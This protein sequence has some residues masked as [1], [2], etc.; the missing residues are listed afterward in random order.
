[1]KLVGKDEVNE[2]SRMWEISLM[3]AEDEYYNSNYM[4]FQIESNVLGM[5]NYNLFSITLLAQQNYFKFLAFHSIIYKIQ[6]RFNKDDKNIDVK[7]K[8]MHDIRDEIKNTDDYHSNPEDEEL[9]EARFRMNIIDAD[10]DLL[11]QQDVITRGILLSAYSQLENIMF[12]LSNIYQDALSLEKNI[13]DIKGSGIER[14]ANYLKQVKGLEQLKGSQIWFE[15][16]NW[17]VIRNQIAHADG[18]YNTKVE[19]AYEYLGLEKYPPENIYLGNGEYEKVYKILI[20]LDKCISFLK[21]SD[22]FLSK[23]VLVDERLLE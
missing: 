7:I 2:F 14:S 4:L 8:K 11:L 20:S 3:N 17:N 10:N 9:S 19:K 21:L 6:E 5:R 15:L 18:V 23:C 13:H 16:T 12:Q 1:M 22:L